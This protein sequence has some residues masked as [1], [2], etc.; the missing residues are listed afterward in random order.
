[1]SILR[2][3]MAAILNRGVRLTGE[4]EGGIDHNPNNDPAILNDDSSFSAS[5][6]LIDLD[7]IHELEISAKNDLKVSDMA[8]NASA[9]FF[10]AASYPNG[11]PEALVAKADLLTEQVADAADTNVD[12]IVPYINP[13]ERTAIISGESYYP[14]YAALRLDQTRLKICGESLASKAAELGRKALDGIITLFE[15]LA[16]FV[17]GYFGTTARLYS[18]IKKIKERAKKTNGSLEKDKITLT[19]GAASTLCVPDSTF[20]PVYLNTASLITNFLD[21]FK[22]FN[23]QNVDNLRS[24]KNNVDE[25]KTLYDTATSDDEA[26]QIKAVLTVTSKNGEIAEG[27][28]S[29]HVADPIEYTK[30]VNSGTKKYIPILKLPNFNFLVYTAPSGTSDGIIDET[31]FNT[32][33]PMCDTIKNSLE[34]ETDEIKKWILNTNPTT[35]LIYFANKLGLT[36]DIITAAE[37]RAAAKSLSDFARQ[38]KTIYKKY[39]GFCLAFLTVAELCEDFAKDLKG[40]QVTAAAP[41]NPKTLAINPAS[42][43][44]KMIVSDTSEIGLGKRSADPNGKTTIKGEVEVTPFTAG[45]VEDLCSTA[46]NLLDDSISYEKSKQYINNATAARKLK[47]YIDRLDKRE[48]EHQP[49]AVKTV[50]RKVF[51]DILDR[52]LREQKMSTELVNEV[53]KF[54]SVVADLCDKSLSQYKND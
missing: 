5:T 2:R 25:S 36:G 29:S 20:K 22:A 44:A 18:R 8:D 33:N 41:K 1:M 24:F 13:S 38:D 47:G 32:A 51:R 40:K 12:N 49:E 31:D 3:N 15:K 35:V 54:I 28:K 19:G 27:F 43:F 34:G 17:R 6:G 14:A 26:E 42:D 53:N 16:Q 4:N 11:A 10:E 9:M 52:G 39:F 7:E 23:S 48:T 45:E 50:Y 46:L 37:K 30:K 21:S